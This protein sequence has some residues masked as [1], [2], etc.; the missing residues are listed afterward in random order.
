MLEEV[1]CIAA[2]NTGFPSQARNQGGAFVP[3]EIFKTYN[4]V[5]ILYSNH[6]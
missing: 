6:F 5:E 3:P 2:D 4:K 1:A